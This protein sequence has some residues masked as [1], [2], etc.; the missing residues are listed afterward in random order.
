MLN[1]MVQALRIGAPPLGPSARRI[2]LALIAGGAAVRLAWTFTT[3]GLPYDMA[4]LHAVVHALLNRPLH[5]YGELNPSNQF[6]WPYPPGFLPWALA[7]HGLES[8]GIPFRVVVALP[9]IAA[10]CALAWVVQA[11]LG[12]RG[13]GERTRVA[14]CALVAFGPAFAL[15][16]ALHGQI[17]SL[18]ILPAV[19]ALLVWEGGDRRRALYAGLLIGVAASIKTAPGLV[20]LALLPS[21]RSRREGVTLCAVSAAIP[22]AAVAPFLIADAPGLLRA[23]GYAGIPGEGGISMLIQ[24]DLARFWV[25]DDLSVR[26]G[27]VVRLFVDHGFALTAAA[28]ALTAAVGWRRRLPARQLAVVLWLALYVLGTAFAFQYAVWG[29]PFLLLAGRLRWAAW[30][31]AVLLVPE[32]IYYLGPWHGPELLIPLYVALMGF[33]WV[34]Q[35][36]ALAVL[37]KGRREARSV[38]PAFA[39]TSR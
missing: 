15:I 18:A 33:L 3:A 24:P 38:S 39:G 25:F 4:S 16:S 30:M 28:I 36:V 37:I 14:A 10:D 27:P 12:R 11:G 34:G 26:V 1:V 29:L 31:Q 9:A 8:V 20:L 21:A 22:L 13:A 17:D 19:L 35:A 2:V 5:L 23:F 6:R 32:L 7:S